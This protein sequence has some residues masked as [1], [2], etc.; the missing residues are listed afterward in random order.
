MKS[1]YDFKPLDTELRKKGF[2]IY[3]TDYANAVDRML[4][5]HTFDLIITEAVFDGMSATQLLDVVRK[6]NDIIP[7]IILLGD[8]DSK[9]EAGNGFT[10]VIKSPYT[11]EA[12]VKATIGLFPGG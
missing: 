7:P 4:S 3:S 1:Y 9:E 2:T 8:K 10:E 11:K 5:V 12:I 6:Y